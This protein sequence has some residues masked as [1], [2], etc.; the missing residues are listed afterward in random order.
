MKNYSN[1]KNPNSKELNKKP[2]EVGSV[3]VSQ[4]SDLYKLPK[5]VIDHKREAVVVLKFRNNSLGIVELHGITDV[6]GNVR[7]KKELRGIWRKIKKANEEVYVDLNIITEDAFGKPIK[8]QS[9][10]FMNTGIKLSSSELQKVFDHIYNFNG[11]K[12]KNL[13]S[14]VKMNNEIKKRRL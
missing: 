1:F 14:V 11:I 2:V 6:N 7:I 3:V 4:L 10:K 9:T 8:Q 5:K 12:S 13:K